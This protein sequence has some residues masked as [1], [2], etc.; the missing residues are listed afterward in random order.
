MRNGKQKGPQKSTRFK[1][2][3]KSECQ[4]KGSKVKYLNYF[5]GSL[6]MPAPPVNSQIVGSK[7]FVKMCLDGK[8]VHSMVQNFHPQLSG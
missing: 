3:E 5:T 8:F 7:C 6:W 4:E 2:E 1:W